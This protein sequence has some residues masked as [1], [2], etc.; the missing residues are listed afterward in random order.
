MVKLLEPC[1]LNFK[2]NCQVYVGDNEWML[3]NKQQIQSQHPSVRSNLYFISYLVCYKY[4]LHC[5][6][7]VLMVQY[8]TT[9]KIIFTRNF[10]SLFFVAIL[11]LDFPTRGWLLLC[12][13]N[14]TDQSKSN[15]IKCTTFFHSINIFF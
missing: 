2:V 7:H 10:W 3:S 4:L 6:K 9:Y 15:G 14:S 11:G 1:Q 12:D 8:T 13:A 5:N